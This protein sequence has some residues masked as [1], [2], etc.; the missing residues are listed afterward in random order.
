MRLGSRGGG[1]LEPNHAA[2]GLH[3]KIMVTLGTSLLLGGSA[4]LGGALRAS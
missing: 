4:G 1:Y 3:C 2:A